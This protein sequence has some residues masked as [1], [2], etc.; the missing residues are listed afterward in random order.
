HAPRTVLVRLRD[1]VPEPSPDDGHEDA[2][3]IPVR[4]I[5]ADGGS[6]EREESGLA[7]GEPA[8]R[9]RLAVE[10]PQRRRASDVLGP[11]VCDRRSPLPSTKT[12]A[13]VRSE[14]LVFEIRRSSGSFF[15]G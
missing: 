3:R 10:L 1:V 11:D 8:G 4:A 13:F 14:F 9:R 12:S 7:P 15:W 6:R 2:D 5:G